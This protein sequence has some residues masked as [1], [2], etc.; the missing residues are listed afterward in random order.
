MAY[1][2]KVKTEMTGTGGGRWDTRANAKKGSKKARRAQ[3]K[4]ARE[5]ADDQWAFIHAVNGVG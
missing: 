4:K 5:E 2:C 3:D 1:S